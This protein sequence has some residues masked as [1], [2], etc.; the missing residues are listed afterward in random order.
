M[1]DDDITSAYA[2]QSPYAIALPSSDYGNPKAYDAYLSEHRTAF[3]EREKQREAIEAKQQLSAD[4]M[5]TILKDAAATIRK[6]REGR[7]NLPLMAL[8][9][10]M[11]GP[12]D[13]GTQVGR[14]LQAMVP[15]IQKQRETDDQEEVT[16]AN[17]GVKA[18]EMKN[19]P[20]KTKLDYLKALQL[21]D[22][23]SIK[24]IEQAQVRAQAQAAKG[25]TGK[26]AI[27]QRLIDEAKAQGKTMSMDEALQRLQELGERN[28]ADMQKVD[29]VNQERKAAGQPPLGFVEAMEEIKRREAGATTSGREAAEVK[30]KAQSALGRTEQG[31]AK[32]YAAIDDLLNDKNLDQYV[33]NIAGT[34][35]EIAP[36]TSQDR[37]NFAN[38]HAFLVNQLFTQAIQPLI[39]TGAGSL[40]DA[41]GKA[42][43]NGFANLKLTSDPE[44]FKRNLQNLKEQLRQSLEN[45][46]RSARGEPVDPTPNR[47][48]TGGT[49][50][51]SSQ[52]GPKSGKK[53]WEKD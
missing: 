27:A 39:G 11:M 2:P 45:A 22:M 12:G 5:S 50:T 43:A 4:Q 10:N 47:P 1:A 33:G 8:G 40:S 6:N 53:P 38:R 51:P 32:G 52:T 15:A 3:A 35:T 19:A 42:L 7:S 41:E 13:F 16:L 44:E 49:P 36:W 21:G 29:R 34:Q 23:N 24:A 9:A 28:P 31:I 37:R 17:L 25:P 20:L 30:V 26:M 46:R 18:E 48:P 14:G